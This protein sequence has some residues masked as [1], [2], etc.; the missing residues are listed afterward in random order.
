M[1]ARLLPEILVLSGENAQAE[2][3]LAAEGVLR[4]V[5]ESRWGSMLI[6]VKEGRVFVNGSLVEAAFMSEKAASRAGRL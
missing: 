6:E 1:N 5:W 4:Y 3:P 2:L